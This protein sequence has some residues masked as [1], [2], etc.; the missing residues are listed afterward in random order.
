[1]FKKILILT[2]LAVLLLGTALFFIGFN[3][4]K[5]NL[6]QNGSLD[7][8]FKLLEIEHFEI[9]P[10]YD[11]VVYFIIDALR[12]DYLNIETKNPNS[13]IHNQFKYL[14]ELMR[15]DE[16]KNH[17]RFYNFKADFPTLTTFKIKSLMS[18]EN[19]GLF[20]LTSSLRPNNNT[21]SSTI[22]KNLFLK[23]KKFVIIGD[24]T[25][26][27]LYNELIHYNY[28]FESLNI[29]D[30]DS[31]DNYI[32]DKIHLFLNHTNIHYEKYNDWKFMVNHFI[33]V[34]HIGHYSGVYNDAMKN[35]LS[36]MD[37]TAVKTLQLLLK[38][39]NQNDHLTPKEFT[40]QVINSIKTNNKSE[41]ILFLLFGDHGQ[42]ENGGHGGSCITETSAG[43]FAFSTIPFIASMEKIPEWDFPVNNK[44]SEQVSLNER[45]KNIKVLNQIDTVPII[46]SSLGIPIPE[47]NLGI[48]REDFKIHL[49]NGTEYDHHQQFLQEI[50][51]A[52][53]MHNNALQIFNRFLHSLGILA[54]LRDHHIKSKYDQFYKSYQLL[55]DADLFRIQNYR[56]DSPPNNYETLISIC[57]KHYQLSYEFALLIQNRLFKDKSKFDW[58]SLTQGI[59]I[60]F[61]LFIFVS[62]IAIPG[63]NLS[64][65]RFMFNQKKAFLSS[66]SEPNEPSPKQLSI[67]NALQLKSGQLFT[68]YLI[69]ILLSSIF[70]LIGLYLS[71]QNFLFTKDFIYYCN[72]STFTIITLIMMHIMIR[73]RYEIYSFYSSIFKFS[74]NNKELRW[75]FYWC[76]MTLM[77]LVHFCSYSASF[78]RNEG[79]IVKFLLISYQIILLFSGSKNNLRQMLLPLIQLIL[80]RFTFIFDYQVHQILNFGLFNIQLLFNS[81]I[82]ILLTLL[83][84]LLLLLIV[85]KNTLNRWN[86]FIM[87]IAPVFVWFEWI[88]NNT[89]VRILALIE[90]TKTIYNSL[91]KRFRLRPFKESDKNV[92]ETKNTADYR[93]IINQWLNQHL[94]LLFLLKKELIVPYSISSIIQLISIENLRL[95]GRNHHN[96]KENNNNNNR[97]SS[98]PI[99]SIE[100]IILLYLLS[101]NNFFN[102]GNK[103]KL[104]TIPEYVGLI[105]LN[106]FH[107]IISQLLVIYFLTS[108]LF[109]LSIVLKLPSLGLRNPR[110]W[111]IGI[112][113]SKYLFTML[114]TII[115]RENIMIWQ[116]LLPKLI[117]ELFFCISFS[118]YFLF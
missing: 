73:Y 7:Q 70:N 115:L 71:S 13:L 25:W 12:I 90:L 84:Y 46:S 112:I 17:I 1:M 92:V 94:M 36:Q 99:K 19:P 42:N 30:F 59:L 44:T 45:I 116:I 107:L 80:I 96:S 93:S 72:F 95:D 100:N 104:E 87:G 9:E 43:F 40:K 89:I 97:L 23:N 110:I 75:N 35:K 39:N 49:E 6:E 8:G 79:K 2:Y 118:I 53:I 51:Y 67:Y 15:S 78:A 113:L 64:M 56:E 103:L 74:L 69:I 11:K 91:A 109:S 14:N 57:K 117:Y 34:D 26:D 4:E 3:G 58:L 82:I 5:T 77:C 62:V 101:L 106:S 85:Y 60:I 41:K 20:E 102:L 81:K 33:G 50:N 48:F 52:K 16:L 32:E 21:E 54:G 98:I 114:G 27:L 111:M 66:S 31:L 24:D 29:R 61:S 63:F 108:H 18:G 47:N 105:G 10:I 88:N 55:K 68:I 65:S 37:Q 38:I 86:I 28:K 22:L 76:I 83:L